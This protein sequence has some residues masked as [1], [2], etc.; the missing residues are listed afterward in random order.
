MILA[1]LGFLRDLIKDSYLFMIQVCT[2]LFYVDRKF[3]SSIS[4]L[5][6][7]DVIL[8][9][10]K[11]KLYKLTLGK[12]AFIEKW[13]VVNTCFGNVILSEGAGIGIGSIVI[14][15]VKFGKRSVCS[16]N[17]FISGESHL[18]QDIS[19]NFLSQGFNIKD[20]IIGDNVWIGS[21]CV[22]LPGVEIG[23][24]A[25]IGAG[26]VVTKSIAAFSVAV[27][28]PAKIIIQY[29]SKMSHWQRLKE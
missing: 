22:I 29:N 24:N 8:C 20:V 14:G 15:P 7:L 2:R 25:V 6:K 26:S 4:L 5:S 21:N 18:Y 17:C 13:T 28:N 16:Q 27:G 11:H 19:K 1:I 10:H 3:P 12:Y 23:D 9:D